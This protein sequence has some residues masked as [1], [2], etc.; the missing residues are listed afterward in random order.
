M[1]KY[2]IWYNQITN[3]AKNRVLDCYTESHHIIPL[4]LGGPDIADNLVNL[5][6]REHFVC[7]W[8]LTKFTTG[9]DRHKMINALRMMRAENHNQQRYKTQITSR[10]YENLKEEYAAL[11]SELRSGKG[12]GMYGKNHTEEARRAISEK[13]KGKQITEEQ[14]QKIVMAKKGVKREAFSDEWIQ[15]MSES[16]KGKNNPRYGVTLSEE[17]KAKM[18]EK[19]LGR[20]QSA[21][22]IAKKIAATKG[23]VREKKLCT[24]CNQQVAVNGYARWHGDNCKHAP[25]R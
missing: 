24:H 16:K 10:V 4:S 21:E 25:Q 14:R 8:L 3:N 18:R 1:N 11:Q 22:T 13:N 9:Q 20:K 12:N 19:A 15:K 5:T 17:T 6:A 23:K 2:E 7:H